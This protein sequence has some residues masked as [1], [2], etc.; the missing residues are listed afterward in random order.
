MGRPGDQSTWHKETGTRVAERAQTLS[1]G[2]RW[3]GLGNLINK[4]EIRPKATGR[5]RAEKA[6]PPIQC[7]EWIN[8]GSQAA[9]RMKVEGVRPWLLMSSLLVMGFCYN[10]GAG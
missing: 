2:V 8:I 4:A 1:A 7:K 5:H 3:A 9:I 6:H 10:V